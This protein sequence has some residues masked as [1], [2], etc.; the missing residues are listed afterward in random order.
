MGRRRII[1]RKARAQSAAR[2]IMFTSP[3]PELIDGGPD[4]LAPLSGE[5]FSVLVKAAADAQEAALTPGGEARAHEA[6]EALALAA[7]AM[8]TG[9]PVPASLRWSAW[10]VHE[11]QQAK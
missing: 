5:V 9:K 11:A 10:Q 8:I 1:F 3:V 2:R 7:D 6:R 4:L